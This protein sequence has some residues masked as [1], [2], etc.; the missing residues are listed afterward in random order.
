MKEIFSEA[1][2]YGT[3]RIMRLYCGYPQFLPLPVSIQHGWAMTTSPVHAVKRA[4][5]NW[6][7]SLAAEQRYATAYPDIATRTSG[8]PFLYLLQGLGYVPLAKAEQKG[9]IVFPSHSTYAIDMVC[10]FDQYAA[11]LAALPRHYHPITVCLYYTD[12]D[13]GLAEPF[14]RHGMSVVTNGQSHLDADFLWNF[15]R[16]VHGKRYIFSNQMSSSLLFGVAMDL[17]AHFWGPEFQ[18][19][20]PNKFWERRDFN[21]YHRAWEAQYREAFRFPDPDLTQQKQVVDE[22]LGRAQMLSP[23]QMRSLLWRLTFH[24]KYRRQLLRVWAQNRNPTIQRVRQT[25]AWQAI[26]H[27]RRKL[28]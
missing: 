4:P 6:Y 12:H 14:S 26:R 24:P 25:R 17:T 13:R 10:D 16:N 8:A 21:Q 2:F 22:E 23:G 1:T 15:V 3:G 20:N 18:V 28:R 19:F 27:V 9:S 5:E 7:W 11:A